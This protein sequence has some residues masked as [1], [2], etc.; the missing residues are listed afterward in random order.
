MH[1]LRAPLALISLSLGLSACA[2][3][4]STLGAGA[5]VPAPELCA[6]PP[7]DRLC[8]FLPHDVVVDLGLGY[9]SLGEKQR[10]FD[11]FSWQSFVALNW[12]ANPDG[13]PAVGP[14]GSNP[15][16]RRV[17]EFYA[18]PLDFLAITTEDGRTATPAAC[19]ALAARETRQVFQLM[20]KSD[21]LDIEPGS[22]LESTGQPLI[23]RNV[24]FVVYDVRLNQVEVGYI[25]DNGLETVEG[26]QRFKEAGK[27]VSFPL[28]SYENEATRSGGSP[29]AIELKTAWRILEVARGDDPSRFYTVEGLVHVP[30][31]NSVSGEAF[32]FQ[33]TLGLVGFHIIQRT[34]S[35]RNFPQNWM[36]STF[37]HVDNAPVASNAADAT[38]FD[39]G[40]AVCQPPAQTSSAYSFFNPACTGPACTANLPPKLRAGETEYRWA[41]SPPYAAAYAI[42]GRFGTQVVRCRSIYSETAA[43]NEAFQRKLAGTVWANYE[44]INT[45]WQGGVEDPTTENGNIPRFLANTTLE[46]YIQTARTRDEVSS[47]LSCHA[48]AKTAAGQDA[49]FSFL[50]RLAKK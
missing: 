22:F 38:T 26:Q 43:L 4:P 34:T 46:T 15:A 6:Q 2:E 1:P 21:H 33:A 39:P 27:T 47:C 35:P 40:P 30:A 23:D 44:L 32:C 25:R 3:R 20:A 14:I 28:G 7:H 45:Q 41:T 42:D 5:D 12:P 29:G 24:N 36:W 18:T 37:E 8:S 17:W 16:A 49:N 31:Q 11:N 19:R 13:S 48:F 50:L 9:S 10:P